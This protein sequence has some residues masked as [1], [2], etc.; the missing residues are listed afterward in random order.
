MIVACGGS[1]APVFGERDRGPVILVKADHVTPGAD[2]LRV[3][4]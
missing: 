2:M 3:L 4:I 1:P